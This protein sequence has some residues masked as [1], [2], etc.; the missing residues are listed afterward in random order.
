MKMDQ[1]TSIGSNTHLE[2]T[3]IK[4]ERVLAYGYCDINS[5]IKCLKFWK[6]GIVTLHC[7]CETTVTVKL[8]NCVDIFTEPRSRILLYCTRKIKVFSNFLIQRHHATICLYQCLMA[9]IWYHAMFTR[10]FCFCDNASFFHVVLALV[11]G[12]A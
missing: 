12:G 10:A 6:I 8:D 2:S 5:D 4:M 3:L 9:D 1:Y 11:D 7:D